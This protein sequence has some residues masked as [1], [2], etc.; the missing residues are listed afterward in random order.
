MKQ[1]SYTISKLPDQVMFFKNLTKNQRDPIRKHM[2]NIEDLRYIMKNT[3]KFSVSYTNFFR[4]SSLKNKDKLLNLL[5]ES[6]INDYDTSRC[7]IFS[8]D[9]K[10]I[11]EFIYMF[12][13]YYKPIYSSDSYEKIWI[14]PKLDI[15]DFISN[16]LFTGNLK[17]NRNNTYL[18]KDGL[19]KLLTIFINFTKY[20]YD[21][22]N[23]DEIS[24]LFDGVN[25]PSLILANI[26]LYEKGY[27]EVVEDLDEIKIFLNK[28]NKNI[29]TED[30]FVFTSDKELLKG[31]I[32]EFIN[33]NSIEYSLE[34]FL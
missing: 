31:H 4:I 17:S 29:C 10:Y 34:D 25:Y 16:S 15:Q 11:K 7:M 21:S 23:E 6:Y 3:S 19:N 22:L 13:D 30:D 24:Y 12:F 18:N 5:I 33:S 27:I 8:D 32:L 9:Y 1:H 28:D 26:V 20:E 2:F 14:Y